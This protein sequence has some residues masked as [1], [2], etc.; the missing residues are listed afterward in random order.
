MCHAWN[1]HGTAC[2]A[3]M[4]TSRLHYMRNNLTQVTE[5]SLMDEHVQWIDMRPKMH[6]KLFWQVGDA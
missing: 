2:G 6:M 4:V 5:L 3:V 1:T